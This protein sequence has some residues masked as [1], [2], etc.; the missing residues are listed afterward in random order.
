MTATALTDHVG[1]VFL[2]GPKEHVPRVDAEWRVALVADKE[3]IGD[4]A[5]M[6]YVKKP[7]NQN[8]IL[9]VATKLSISITID[10]AKP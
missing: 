6:E 2:C 10:A 3:P 1:G 4:R 7:V 5:D 9:P 8:A